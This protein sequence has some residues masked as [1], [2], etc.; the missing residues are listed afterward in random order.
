MLSGA[1]A[2]QLLQSVSGWYAK[3][4]DAVRRV[5]LTQFLLGG[6]LKIR[7]KARSVFAIP[8]PLRHVVCE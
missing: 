3:V 2:D 7:A 5:Q 8:H 6:T 4:V 1:I